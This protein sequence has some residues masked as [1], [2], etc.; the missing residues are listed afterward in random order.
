MDMTPRK[1]FLKVKNVIGEFKSGLPVTGDLLR[2]SADVTN[3]FYSLFNTEIKSD[4]M[5][6][7]DTLIPIKH[8]H[9][10][11]VKKLQILIFIKTI[12]MVL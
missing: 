7:L 3:V 1:N 6:L 12:H 10:H 4:I 8:N 11:L 2:L 9:L 5:T